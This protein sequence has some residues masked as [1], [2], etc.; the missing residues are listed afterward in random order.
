MAPRRSPR[1]KNISKEKKEEL[2]SVEI[3]KKICVR[4]ISKRKNASK[5]L[6]SIPVI[7]QQTVFKN[8]N[9][10]K[11]QKIVTQSSK[12]GVKQQQKHMLASVSQPNCEEGNSNVFSKNTSFAGDRTKN[13]IESTSKEVLEM[14]YLVK[15]LK[16]D[17]KIDRMVTRRSKKDVKICSKNEIPCSSAVLLS[18]SK[19]VS[20]MGILS[21]V[22]KPLAAKPVI[23]VEP[24]PNKRKPKDELM[25]RLHFERNDICF[26]KMTGHAPWPAQ[27]RLF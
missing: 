2:G 7:Q 3:V 11:A 4:R 14:N 10:S 18:Q 25:K 26:A 9:D 6:D 17:T 27:V 23:D 15:S 21:A 24:K 5:D 16:I 22:S 19:D 8:K 1:I 13:K 20:G 12:V